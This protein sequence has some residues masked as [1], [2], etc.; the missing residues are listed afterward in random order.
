MLSEKGEMLSGKVSKS[1][2]RKSRPTLR[3]SRSLVNPKTCLPHSPTCL[4]INATP[5]YTRACRNGDKMTFDHFSCSLWFLW[6]AS[7]VWRK[8]KVNKRHPILWLA[9][10]SLVL[11]VFPLSDPTTELCLS[12]QLYSNPKVLTFFSRIYFVGPQEVQDSRYI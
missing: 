9:T 10:L 6:C 3:G 8:L 11:A 1:L 4:T 12:V 2:G 5:N 7:F